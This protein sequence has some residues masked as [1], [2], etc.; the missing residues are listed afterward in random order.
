MQEHQWAPRIEHSWRCRAYIFHTQ[1]T[2]L[3]NTPPHPLAFPAP[4]PVVP[5][6]PPC[7]PLKVPWLHARDFNRKVM[8][9]KNR[10]RSENSP[11]FFFPTD[12]LPFFCQWLT[13]NKACSQPILT[14]QFEEPVCLTCRMPCS[15]MWATARL[16]PIAMTRY[17]HSSDRGRL[18]GGATQTQGEARSSC[19]N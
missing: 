19:Q 6:L 1:A 4:G 18:V 11:V 10:G 12:T 2:M 14:K 8:C 9:S 15:H 3:Q 17:S 7:L 13:H 16:S 5:F